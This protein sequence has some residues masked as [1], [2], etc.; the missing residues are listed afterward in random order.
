MRLGAKLNAGVRLIAAQQFH[1]ETELDILELPCRTEE[2]VALDLRGQRAGDDRAG[3]D[4]EVRQVALPAG[5]RLAV[6]QRGCRGLPRA[7][8]RD[9]HHGDGYCTG[10]R[11]SHARPTMS[12][13]ALARQVSR[14]RKAAQASRSALGGL[15]R[16]RS[17]R[18]AQSVGGLTRCLQAC[19]PRL[20]VHEHPFGGQ[21]SSAWIHANASARWFE[22]A[23]A[24]TLW[25]PGPNVCGQSVDA[26]P[27]VRV[28]RLECAR[29]RR[30]LLRGGCHATILRPS[31]GELE[32]IR[33]DGPNMN[34]VLLEAS[35]ERRRG[36]AATTCG[37]MSPRR[38]RP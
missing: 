1:G 20:E 2:F 32:H 13:S 3:F 5:E 24:W 27:H 15:A 22:R 33:G 35:G 9:R 4:P 7:D 38:S 8:E 11:G 31:P 28:L 12:P 16:I 29:R 34:D 10:E 21:R 19:E 25:A 36:T 23:T 6:E 30:R 17:R 14:P 26:S 18:E 37:R